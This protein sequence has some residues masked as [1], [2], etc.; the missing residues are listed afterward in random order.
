MSFIPILNVLR[1]FDS[2][3]AVR[4]RFIGPKTW[5]L[6]DTKFL[7]QGAAVAALGVVWVGES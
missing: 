7:S 1:M 2:N 4:G 3:E 5:D 6:I